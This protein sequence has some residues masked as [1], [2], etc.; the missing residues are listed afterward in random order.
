L[1]PSYEE[2][3]T[4]LFT[5]LVRNAFHRMQTFF[6]LA[7]TRAGQGT[8]SLIGR[9]VGNPQKTTWLNAR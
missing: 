8:W 9:S 5:N 7:W 4:T 2:I 6:D 3:G 1:I